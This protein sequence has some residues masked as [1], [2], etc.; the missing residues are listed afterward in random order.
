MA[1]IWI[2]VSLLILLLIAIIV[3]AVLLSQKCKKAFQDAFGSQYGSCFFTAAK[4]NFSKAHFKQACQIIQKCPSVIHDCVQ[5]LLL[6]ESKILPTP[7]NILSMI[8]QL[9][10][11]VGSCVTDIIDYSS[12]SAQEK[13][14]WLQEL[15]AVSTYILQQ[16]S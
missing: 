3:V 16:C 8:Q 11:Q 13:Q 1:W 9:C 15:T 12:L 5:S 4:K 14:Q 10:P 2:L 7:S 6:N